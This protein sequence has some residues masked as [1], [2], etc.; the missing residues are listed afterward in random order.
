M[1]LQNC[2]EQVDLLLILN[3]VAPLNRGISMDVSM[4]HANAVKLIFFSWKD[5]YVKWHETVERIHCKKP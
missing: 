1:R 2:Y 3:Y 5:F 4:I